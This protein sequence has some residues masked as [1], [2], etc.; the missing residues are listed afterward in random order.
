MSLL[1]HLLLK[2]APWLGL[3]MFSSLAVAANSPYEVSSKCFFVY[4]PVFE[5]G[6]DTG[7]EKLKNYG[8]V[9]MAWISGY[10]QTNKSNAEFNEVFNR[11]LKINKAMGIALEERL[12]NALR[13]RTQKAFNS[14][15]DEVTACDRQLG[16]VDQASEK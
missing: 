9:R 5:V 1:T 15:L 3:F 2:S 13:S 11:N 12:R 16:F 6:R 8:Q 10:I 14:V 7:G 4:A